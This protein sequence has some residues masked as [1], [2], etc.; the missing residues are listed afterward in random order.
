MSQEKNIGAFLFGTLAGL[1][2]AILFA[3]Q[4]GS[5]TRRM[6]AEN[7]AAARDSISAEA[8]YLTDSLMRKSQDLRETLTKSLTGN[9]RSFDEQL[10]GLLTNAS[11]STEEVIERLEQHLKTLKRKN[12]EFRARERERQKEKIL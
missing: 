6:I 9:K 11:Y 4:K 2:F 8:G 1:G 5:E 12:R 10:I 3:P 7:S